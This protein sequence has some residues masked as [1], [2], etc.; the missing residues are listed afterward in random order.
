MTPINRIF[1][2]SVS[3]GTK[4]PYTVENKKLWILIITVP[5]LS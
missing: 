3:K 2:H 5:A 4:S 1:A